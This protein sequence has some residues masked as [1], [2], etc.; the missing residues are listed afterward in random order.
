[1]RRCALGRL[2]EMTFPVL[3]LDCTGRVAHVGQMAELFVGEF[4]FSKG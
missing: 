1:M 4:H 3:D 2:D